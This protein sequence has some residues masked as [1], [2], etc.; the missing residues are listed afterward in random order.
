MFEGITEKDL[1]SH[2]RCEHKALFYY[3]VA[4]LTCHFAWLSIENL[5]FLFDLLVSGVEWRK[6]NVAVAWKR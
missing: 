3:V 2:F 5:A 4:T 1:Q 6:H